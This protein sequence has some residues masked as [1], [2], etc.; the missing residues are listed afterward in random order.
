MRKR[1]KAQIQKQRASFRWD[2]L[3]K[4]TTGHFFNH[5]PIKTPGLLAKCGMTFH[6]DDIT[7]SWIEFQ[8]LH[9]K[10]VRMKGDWNTHTHTKTLGVQY[11]FSTQYMPI[12][13]LLSS[14]LSPPSQ[15]IP[16][17]SRTCLLLPEL[18]M[19]MDGHLLQTLVTVRVFVSLGA[20][21]VC[22]FWKCSL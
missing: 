8:F 16:S 22:F 15:S 14:P 21:L 11:V 6:L 12:P 7:K 2:D 13:L 4:H 5:A 20:W 9:V 19:P 1:M 3:S 17:C 10:V 18:I